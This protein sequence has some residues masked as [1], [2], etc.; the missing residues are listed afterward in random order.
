MRKFLAWFFT[1][2]YFLVFCGLIYLIF[3]GF[4]SKFFN[5]F[6]AESL[7]TIFCWIIAFFVSVGLGDF[8]EKKIR[9]YYS[10]K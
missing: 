9:D 7:F 5:S 1:I 6:A 3:T 2:V 10:K 4:L 8:T